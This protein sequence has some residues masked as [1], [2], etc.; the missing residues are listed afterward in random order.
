MLV[1]FVARKQAFQRGNCHCM[2]NGLS[3]KCI[4]FQLQGN[5]GCQS[6]NCCHICGGVSYVYGS[7]GTQT[8]LSLRELHVAVSVVVSAINAHRFSGKET[9]L[10][11]RELLPYLW[12]CQL[13]IWFQWQANG[14]VSQRTACR[15]ICSGLSYKCTSFQWQGNGVVSQ[16]TV[17]VSVMVSAMHNYGFSGK[18]A[19]LSE[20][21][22]RNI[23][24]GAAPWCYVDRDTCTRQYCEPCGLGKLVDE[25]EV[26]TIML[27]VMREV[28]MTM[29]MMMTGDGNERGDDDDDM[30]DYDSD[31]ANGTSKSSS[32]RRRRSK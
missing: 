28:L 26:T 20:N 23:G 32:R 2:C 1:V 11:V 24:G 31:E 8:G 13:C 19:D 12:W 17:V 4:S 18:E 7:S 6:E 16:R 27:M 30:I 25:T 14:V 21:Y 22:C 10:S 5:G 3:Y 29:K 15:L 9:G